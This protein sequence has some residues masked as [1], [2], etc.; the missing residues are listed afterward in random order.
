MVEQI[1]KNEHRSYQLFRCE[2]CGA[3]HRTQA[4][5]ARCE[6]GH[7]CKHENIKYELVEATEG[8]WF[9]VKGVS[10]TCR[11]CR[12]LIG[13]KSFE[14]IEDNQALLKQIYTLIP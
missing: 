7:A 3:E 6:L 13:E 10:A 11:D 1:T 2:I 4:G 5:A 9:D 12:K 14:A 8:W